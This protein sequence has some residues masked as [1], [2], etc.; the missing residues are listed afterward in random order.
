ML[1]GADGGGKLFRLLVMGM[2]A[3]EMGRAL[4][5]INMMQKLT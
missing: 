4:E 1:L 3:F 2:E 5:A